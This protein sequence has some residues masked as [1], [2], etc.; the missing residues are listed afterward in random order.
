[1]T[2]LVKN[3]KSYAV[4]DQVK[5]VDKDSKY[6]M[7]V[8]IV[9]A[10]RVKDGEAEYL[11]WY[12]NGEDKQAIFNNKQIR[13]ITRV[14]DETLEI[15]KKCTSAEDFVEKDNRENSEESES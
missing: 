1:M 6:I 13:C 4:G 11:V 10:S 14:F 2:M 7:N 3:K 8:G 12:L 5:I 9:V 15:A